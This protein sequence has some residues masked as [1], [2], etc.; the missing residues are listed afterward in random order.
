MH[1]GQERRANGRTLTN[2]SALLSIRGIQG[3]YTCGVRDMNQNGASLRINGPPLLPTEFS[4]S[5]DGLRTKIAC[6]LIWRDGDFVGVAFQ[7]A[8]DSQASLCL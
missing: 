8:A 1:F 5:L 7:G 2:G 3:T 6:R 4:L